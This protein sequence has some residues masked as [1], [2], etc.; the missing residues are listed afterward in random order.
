ML[1]K[2]DTI[3]ITGGAGFCGVNLCRYFV[4]KGFE[5]IIALDISDFNY[6][7]VADKVEFVK[8]DI[9]DRELMDNLTKGVKHV[10]HCAAALPT[11]PEEDI[12]SIEIKG[13]HRVLE[14]ALRNGV[15]RV[16]NISSGGVY[17][18]PDH[19]PLHEDDKL[20]PLG[21]YAIAKVKT[22]KLSRQYWAKGLCSPILRP[23]PIEG[24]ERLGIMSI[25]FEWNRLGKNIPIIGTG[26]NKFQLIDIEDFCHAVEQCLIKDK[27]AV[28]NVFNIGSD[29][30]GTMEE[31]FGAII[32]YRGSKKRVIPLPAGPVIFVLSILEKLRLSPLYEWLYRSAPLDNV[33]DISRA[34][35]VLDFAP[36][37]SNADTLLRNYK[38]YEKNYKKHKQGGVDHRSVW[39]QGII[40]VVS[41][42]F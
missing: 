16:V 8:G 19:C 18:V 3:L 34:K 25:Y 6:P 1:S 12:Y 13:T 40:R 15:E 31:D 10:V 20:N 30:F 7:D 26:K 28:N 14:A 24:P 4:K 17:G 41:W 39:K 32:K 11:Y 5:N 29:K 23:T 36:K 38:W 2:D 27:E 37:Y 33:F 9:R 21:A 35:K 22:E 42:F